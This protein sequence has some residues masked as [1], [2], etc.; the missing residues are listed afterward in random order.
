MKI[1]GRVE[2]YNSDRGF[3]FVIDVDETHVK[4][5]FHQSHIVSGTPVTG[6]LCEYEIGQTSKGP[7]ALDVEI[8]AGTSAPSIPVI[9][10]LESGAK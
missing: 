7:V 8:F 10:G 5:F 9:A 2:Y 6:R 4:R 1:L 3:G